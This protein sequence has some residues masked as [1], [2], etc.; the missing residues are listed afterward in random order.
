MRKYILTF[1]LVLLSATCVAQFRGELSTS[2][3]GGLEYSMNGYRATLEN[4][5]FDALIFKDNKS[6]KVEYNKEYLA[7]ANFGVDARAKTAMFNALIH[8]F[9]QKSGYSETFSVDIFDDFIYKD[10]K[11]TRASLKKDIFDKLIYTD[12]KGN[13]LTYSDEFIR[14]TFNRSTSDPQLRFMIFNDLIQSLWLGGKPQLNLRP[15]GFG[16]PYPD[17]FFPDEDPFGG[18]GNYDAPAN[19]LYE[20]KNK[21]EGWANITSDNQGNFIY[22]DSRGNDFLF[23]GSSWKSKARKFRS[24]ENFFNYLI[25]EYLRD[26]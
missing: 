17:E 8:R 10:N 3:N 6:N 22:Q 16:K 14:E 2:F 1:A 19:Y 7:Y 9:Q 21:N 23:S 11:G 5:I 13:K 4:N 25:R 15:G 20:Y 12:S 26:N 24:E 18:D